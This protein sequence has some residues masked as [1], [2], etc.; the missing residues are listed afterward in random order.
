[1]NVFKRPIWVAIV[2]CSLALVPGVSTAG[3]DSFFDIFYEVSY[4]RVSGSPIVQPQGI[5]RDTQNGSRKVD[6]EMLSMSLTSR[7]SG[8]GS[9]THVV[10]LSYVVRNI[11]SSGEDGVRSSKK[12]DTKGYAEVEIVCSGDKC[13]VTSAKPI[14][15]AHHRG[16]VTVLK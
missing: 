5:I 10:T 15:R 9:T 6:T 12:G 8:D 11:G 14:S 3:V 7:A 1:M 16:H 4:D 2:V 13:R